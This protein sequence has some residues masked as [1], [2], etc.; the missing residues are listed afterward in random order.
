LLNRHLGGEMA[1]RLLSG[2]DFRQHGG[3]VML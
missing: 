3:F 1:V 2:T